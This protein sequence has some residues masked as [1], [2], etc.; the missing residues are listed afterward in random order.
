MC[1]QNNC[2]FVESS[3]RMLC[4]VK[5]LP[6]WLPGTGFKYTARTY[7]ANLDWLAQGPFEFVKNAMVSQG[8]Y[9]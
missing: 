8:C 4:V 5:H 2:G 1:V 9:K 6:E 3:H 7:A